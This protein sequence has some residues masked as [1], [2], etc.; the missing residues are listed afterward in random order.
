MLLKFRLLALFL[1]ASSCLTAYAK[2]PLPLGVVLDDKGQPIA[3]PDKPQ[4][5]FEYHYVPPTKRYQ[6][7]VKAHP[8][9][10]KK[11]KKLSRKQLLASRQSVANDAG[12]RW[13]D[14]RMST[15]EKKLTLGVNHRNQH[16]Q[17]E[18]L[19]RQD[20]WECLKC[21]VE[22]PAQADHHSCQYRR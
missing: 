22:G 13:L 11:S 20:E 10:Q 7:T 18:L 6:Q 8:S 9:N 14:S 2:A 21:G 19:V 16:H 3:I 15:L 4:S 12:C 5:H 17:Q 1:L